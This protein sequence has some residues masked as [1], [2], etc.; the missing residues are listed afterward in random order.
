MNTVYL[1]KIASFNIM[2]LFYYDI[3]YVFKIQTIF[4]T[5]VILLSIYKSEECKGFTKLI[6]TSIAAQ[7]QATTVDVDV[8]C[9]VALQ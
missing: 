9:L 8:P 5:S 6:Y 1:C 2:K 4:L 3:T 7:P